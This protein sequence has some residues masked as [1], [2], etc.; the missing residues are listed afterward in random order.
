MYKLVFT[1]IFQYNFRNVNRCYR[2]GTKVT[3]ESLKHDLIYKTFNFYF[4]S[5]I[6]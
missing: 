3:T 5:L 6:I 2:N 1:S 4:E